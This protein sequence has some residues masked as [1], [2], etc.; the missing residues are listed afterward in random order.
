MVIGYGWGDEHINDPIA[1]AVRDNGLQVYSWN[2]AH[3]REMLSGK[4]RG[5]EI[6]HGIM[7]FSS[8]MMREVMPHNPINSGSAHYNGIVE[9]FF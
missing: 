9:D 3:P 1:D 2:P 7:G 6:S 5:D 8:R 4:H